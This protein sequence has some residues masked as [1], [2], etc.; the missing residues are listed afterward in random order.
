MSGLQLLTVYGGLLLGGLLMSLHCV[1]MC[2]PIVIGFSQAFERVRLT[3]RG[4]PLASGHSL[5]W[6]LAWDFLWYHAGRIW[7]YA[8]LG[9]AAGW[10]GEGIRRSAALMGWRQAAG[11]SL[12]LL[13]V[14]SGIA[15]LGIVPGL[16]L[17]RLVAR[18]GASEGRRRPMLATLLA[19]RGA[20]PRLLLGV[21]MGF[22]PCGLVYAMLAVTATLPTPWHAAVGM[23][24]FGLGTVPAL[25]AV[26][27]AMGAVP[28]RWRVQGMKLAA[29]LVIVSGAWLTARAWHTAPAACCDGYGTW[30]APTDGR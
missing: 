22:L 3:I 28:H 12:G 1:G 26:L 2:G 27:L 25:T 4:Q 10:L 9:F 16:S 21:V 5:R 13:V 11:V 30:V 23:V 15:L 24:A 19:G 7:T 14:V 6:G 20:A 8:L 18:C 29:V 17:E